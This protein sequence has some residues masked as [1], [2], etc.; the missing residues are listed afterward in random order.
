MDILIY[1]GG[2]SNEGAK[3]FLNENNIKYDIVA[4]KDKYDYIVKPPGVL[5]DEIKIDGKI[6]CDIELIYMLKHPLIIGVTGSAGKTTTSILINNI[7]NKK[8]NTILAGNIGIPFGNVYKDN[9]SIYVLELSSFELE[10][11]ISLRPR[12]A[13]M[14]NITDAHL[15]Y[16]KTM[17]NYINS[18]MMITKNQEEYDFL[19]YNYDDDSLVKIAASSRTIKK[20]FSLK[21]KKADVYLDN[22]KIITKKHEYKINDEILKFEGDI[23]NIMASILV[24]ELCN[25]DYGI[26]LKTINEFKKPKYRM[27]RIGPNIYNDAKSTNVLSTVKQIKSF[28][29]VELI[30]GGY[31]RGNDLDL[32]KE[33][34]P[35]VDKFYLYGANSKRVGIFLASCNVSYQ[36]FDNLKD[37]SL[38]ALKSNNTIIFS[39]M[40]PSYDQYSSYIKRGEEFE[41]VVKEKMVHY[42]PLD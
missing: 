23:C 25:V 30:C 36:I 11:C 19:I 13:V 24:G 26:V 22:N 18:K 34:F 37:A 15:D 6:I 33:L 17:D 32:M 31:D 27:E 21:N 4:C 5:K 16:H 2:I 10:S 7:L 42:E 8:Y 38:E 29:N 1:K 40:A 39:P 12:I 20:C 35:Y 14:L 9:N 28:K 41:R 3:K